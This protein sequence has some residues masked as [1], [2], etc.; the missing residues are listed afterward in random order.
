MAEPEIVVASEIEDNPSHP[1][2]SNHESQIEAII[3]SKR[4]RGPDTFDES[5]AENDVETV[6]I[7]DEFTSPN[8]R[9]EASDELST[10]LGTTNKRINKC[11]SKTLVTYT[12]PDVG[13][14]YT[15]AMNDFL[16][17]FIQGIM[18]PD[19]KSLSAFGPCSNTHLKI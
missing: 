3:P 6:V 4:P 16:K 11:D 17:P 12:R 19:K 1:E 18:A 5:A 10:F 14:V 8:S 7:D 9:W 15:S 2:A 13:E